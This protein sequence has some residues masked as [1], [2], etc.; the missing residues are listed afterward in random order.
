MH[1]DRSLSVGNEKRHKLILRS[2]DGI[3]KQN[4]QKRYFSTEESNGLLDLDKNGPKPRFFPGVN[5]QCL[6]VRET[7]DPKSRLLCYSVTVDLSGKLGQT[8]A[9]HIMD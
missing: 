6:H 2:V 7:I 5:G 8:S 4:G 9:N 3:L 1:F